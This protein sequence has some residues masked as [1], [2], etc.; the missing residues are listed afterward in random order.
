MI[1]VEVSVVV[2]SVGAAP[3]ANAVHAWRIIHQPTAFTTFT[4]FD[5]FTTAAPRVDDP[6]PIITSLEMV[7]EV[8]HQTIRFVTLSPVMPRHVTPCR[9]ASR[10]VTAQPNLTTTAAL[11]VFAG[12]PWS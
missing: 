2:A 9:V 4:T 1:R 3:S 6:L 10:H 12:I 11:L 5:T 7:R 8:S